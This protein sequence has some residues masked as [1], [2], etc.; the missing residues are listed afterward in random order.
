VSLLAQNLETIVGLKMRLESIEEAKSAREDFNRQQI[1][2]CN[3]V[4]KRI[5]NFTKTLSNEERKHEGFEKELDKLI[6]PQYYKDGYYCG[7]A[8]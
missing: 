5:D 1:D 6:N 3:N 2:F 4:S 8:R 7:P